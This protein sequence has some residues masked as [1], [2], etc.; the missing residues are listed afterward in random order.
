MII[1][2]VTQGTPEWHTARLGVPTASNFYKI[3]SPT[4]KK[5]TQADGY[6]NDLMSEM[7]T[8]EYDPLDFKSSYMDRGKELEAQAAQLYAFKHNVELTPVGFVT[9]DARTMGCSPDA[10]VGDIGGL[11]IKCLKPKNH[12]AQMLRPLVDDEYKPQVQGALAVLDAEW[13]DVMAFHPKMQP[14]IIRVARDEPYI[15]QF[16]IFLGEFHDLMRE[17][18]HKLIRMGAEFA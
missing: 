2:D 12:V 13:W 4:G 10:L 7:M 18:K 14:V 5:S 6:A 8:G 1:Y 17:K 11:E 15:K 9:D 16:R 3:I